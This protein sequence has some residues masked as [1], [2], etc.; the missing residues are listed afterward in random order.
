MGHRT[1]GEPDTVT[2]GL[3][4]SPGAA[5]DLARRVVNELPHLLATASPGVGWAVRLV[6]DQLVERPADLS[7]LITAARRRMMDE[8]WHLTI[9]LTDLPLQTARRPVVAH[10]SATHSVAVLSLPALGPIAVAGRALETIVRLVMA[11]LTGD[12]EQAARELGAR[13]RTDQGGG[14]GLVTGVVTGNL[15]LLLGMLRAN[16]PWRLAMHLSRAL[17]AAVAV[18]VFALVTSDVWRLAAGSG[19]GRLGLLTASSIVA[20]VLTI[21][22]GADL[23]ERMPANAAAKEQVVLFNVVTVSTVVIGVLALYFALFVLT[24][25]GV[26]LLVSEANLATALGRPA[27]STDLLAIAW[28][29]CSL[30]TV[31]GALGAGLESDESVREAAYNYQPDRTLL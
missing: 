30:A 13:V 17:V 23:L 26:L 4:A 12:S 22:V 5:S 20:V 28:M 31:G 11:L 6:V 29:A 27:G 7:Q 8:G 18:G 25:G 21:V 16:R 3:V 14:V 9:C 24:V 1:T 19:P 10:A 2:V 15:R